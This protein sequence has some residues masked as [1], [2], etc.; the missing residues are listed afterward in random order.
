MGI[1]DALACVRRVSRACRIIPTRVMKQKDDNDNLTMLLDADAATLRLPTRLELVGKT[2]EF[3]RE[4]ATSCGVCDGRADNLVMALHEALTNAI[5]HGN[6]GIS[7]ELKEF[8]GGAFAKALAERSA[9][10]VLASR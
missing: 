9:D 10:P 7:S 8:P 1:D 3:L 5:V 6:L 2:V 4:R